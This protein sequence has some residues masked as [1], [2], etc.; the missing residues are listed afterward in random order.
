M[1]VP[2]AGAAD[3]EAVIVGGDIV[4]RDGKLAGDH[5]AKAR[6]LMRES[7]EHLRPHAPK[8]EANL[9]LN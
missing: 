4:K 5:V 2:K 6:T 1:M 9:A 7:R 8:V 3:V